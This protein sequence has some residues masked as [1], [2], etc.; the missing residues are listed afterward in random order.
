[1][2]FGPLLARSGDPAGSMI[3]SMTEDVPDFV[4]VW[5]DPGQRLWTIQLKDRAGNQIG[6]AE[7]AA[8][9]KD[10]AG[11]GRQIA[12]AQN[13]DVVIVRTREHG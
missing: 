2:R 6:D 9:K 7:H 12:H 3:R 1:M 5:W 13:I 10:A 11:R 8:H 4:E